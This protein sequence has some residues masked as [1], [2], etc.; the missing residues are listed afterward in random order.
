MVEMQWVKFWFKAILYPPF[1]LMD[2]R[3]HYEEYLEALDAILSFL[4]DAEA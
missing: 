2:T 3:V 1:E 4:A